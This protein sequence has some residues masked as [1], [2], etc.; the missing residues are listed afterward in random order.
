MRK[1]VLKLL[2]L[3]IGL[4]FLLYWLGK[5]QHYFIKSTGVNA[6]IT[7]DTQLV[8]GQLPE[9][10][11]AF[12]QGGEEAGQPM[13]RSIIK[14]IRDLGPRYLRLDHL[15]DDD[16]YGL[17]ATDS[18]ELRLNWTKLDQT[19]DD[20][21]ASGAKP[22]LSLSYLPSALNPDKVGKPNDWQRWQLLVQKTIEHYSGKDQRNL[23]GV[24][25]EVWN[26]PDLPQF[27]GWKLRGEK[28]YL[29]LY[30]YAARGALAAKNTNRFKFGGPATAA[31]YENWVKELLELTQKENL[32]LDFISWHRYSLYPQAY[33]ADVEK[34]TDL[35]NRDYPQRGL[36]EKVISEWG[37]T[38]ERDKRYQELFAAAHALAV[39]R[40]LGHRV[41]WVFAFELKDG[42][43]RSEQG[44]GLLTHESQSKTLKPRYQIYRWFNQLAPEQLFL[45]GEG[46]W[47]TGWASKQGQK[48]D[49]LLVNY[50]PDSSHHELTPIT[51]KNLQPGSYRLRE[52]FL[53]KAATE[54][55]ELVE[56]SILRKQIYFEPESVVWLQLIRE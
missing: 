19:V 3:F 38:Q 12:A 25:Y 32:P 27:G 39:I 10:W 28:N 37:H 21:L 30:R 54:T 14:E 22:F 41:R 9:S 50:D 43:F 15:F 1:S 45:S 46:S 2:I 8:V 56:T 13:L 51:F 49:L 23:T 4:G 5:P 20:I 42:P 40:Q 53:T 24:Y 47:V 17:I 35:L 33:L 26:E 16:F 44:W 48:I 6:N 31:Y 7:V 55:R 36:I 29:E 34:L 18:A 11:R 52:Q